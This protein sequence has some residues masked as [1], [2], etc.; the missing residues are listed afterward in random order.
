MTITGDDLLKRH[1]AAMTSGFASSSVVYGAVSTRGNFDHEETLVDGPQGIVRS[2]AR[3]LIV[4][5]AVF[6]SQPTRD[7]TITIDAVAY[8]VRSCDLQG[9]GKTYRIE[10]ATDG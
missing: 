3:T 1:V 8:L 10:V 7:S 4:P 6:P 9:D 5:A 2:N